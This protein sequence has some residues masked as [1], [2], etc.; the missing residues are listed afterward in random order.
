MMRLR[1]W[2]V[3]PLL[4]VV[5]LA[6][7]ASVPPPLPAL[8][9]PS[10]SIQTPITISFGANEQR[11][12]EF[13][14]LIDAFQNVNPDIRVQ[15]QAIDPV[16]S[17]TLADAVRSLDTVV[18]Y[19]VH[20]AD[21]AAGVVTD[22][23]P[24]ADAD[25]AFAHTDFY[26]R[27]GAVGAGSTPFYVVP[28]ALDVPLLAYNTELWTS[29]GLPPPS[30]PW[31]WTVLRAQA[32]QLAERPG[33]PDAVYGL[34][35]PGGLLTFHGELE[36]RGRSLH[37]DSAQL[38]SQTELT[39][40]LST[41]RVLASQGVIATT[42]DDATRDDVGLIRAGR[43][44]IWP[45]TRMGA[46]LRTG[47]LPFPVGYAPNTSGAQG[48]LMPT[49]VVMSSG[50]ANPQGAWRWISFLSQQ[51]VPAP[52]STA[53]GVFRLPAR[54]STAQREPSWSGDFDL[55]L[56]E[57]I[58]AF[59]KEAPAARST[60]GTAGDT[61]PAL[62]ETIRLVV[63]GTQSP[64]EAAQAFQVALAQGT[65]PEAARDGS[66]AGAAFTVPTPLPA[67][68]SAGVTRI[69]FAPNNQF[70]NTWSDPV[71]AAF[72]REHPEIEVVVVEA[73]EEPASVR[74][75][76]RA[77]DCFAYRYPPQS[78][79]ITAT[80]DLQ[81][82]LDVDSSLLRADLAAPALVAFQR[83]GRLT[84]L[85][86]TQSFPVL[87]YN[88]DRFDAVG[89]PYPT[90]AWTIQDVQAAADALTDMRD[91]AAPFY[92]LAADGRMDL[93]LFLDDASVALV[94]STQSMRQPNFT[95][96]QVI[97]A[98][99]Q[100]VS[101]VQRT[102]P[103]AGKT[104]YDDP[105]TEALVWRYDQVGMF[106]A[107]DP[108]IFM[109]G[110]LAGVR[111]G[112]ALLRDVRPTTYLQPRGFFIS[113]QTSAPEACWTLIRYLSSTDVGGVFSARL[114]ASEVLVGSGQL[115]PGSVE[116]YQRF[117]QLVREPVDTTS[118]GLFLAEPID[119]YWL[120]RGLNRAI[121]GDDL[122]SAMA[123]AQQLTEQYLLCRFDGGEAQAC[124]ETTDAE[125]ARN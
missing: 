95:D 58:E 117:Q 15:F 82:F 107:G 72:R 118:N 69:T 47:A 112:V 21:I 18:G 65:Q 73:D 37:D 115:L 39:D 104:V 125:F 114:S 67:T 90:D 99:G 27:A 98:L 60:D 29:R 83:E 44:G 63:Q 88:R 10:A 76:A 79:E 91:P 35:D 25:G 13:E 40:V 75:A 100:Y 20:A 101:L 94:H 68:Q 2:G 71:F 16:Q 111:Y 56:V 30:A 113:A 31:T 123:E 22:L 84:G 96:P 52:S 77:A 33:A 64:A 110:N 105:T 1:G 14:P 46:V 119:S 45:A 38:P 78:D 41:V 61:L 28:L 87:F 42:L 19:P 74:D 85:P 92:G 48:Q 43:I 120:R 51:Y 32:E 103:F 93:A 62:E 8:P 109:T 55:A 122:R 86:F 26:P 57:Q 6:A 106:F 108:Y 121:Q 59:L 54:E 5:A 34:A 89:L 11:R 116:S 7:C 97:S 9:A 66:S 3:L 50:T 124:A 23:S 53:T 102:A 17:P 12:S 70:G 24:F 36:A 81:P 49:G 4:F 80:L